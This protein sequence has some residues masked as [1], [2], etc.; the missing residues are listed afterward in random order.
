MTCA[1]LEEQ[2]TYPSGRTSQ[3][4]PTCN[5]GRISGSRS[6]ANLP[7]RSVIAAL[8]SANSANSGVPPAPD[9]NLIGDRDDAL[10][11]LRPAAA[12]QPGTIERDYRD[13]R[14]RPRSW[15]RPIHA[16]PRQSQAR[17][18]RQGCVPSARQG[19][20]LC[21]WRSAARRSSAPHPRPCCAR[22]CSCRADAHRMFLRTTNASFQARLKA[23]CMPVF[24][25]CPPAGLWTCAASPATKARPQR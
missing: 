9:W 6:P 3:V 18:G 15:C 4:P 5:G 24:M 25:P 12:M 19:S 11:R 8:G 16:G 17:R 23:S 10:A 14:S 21:R 1:S 22:G 2:A 13:S 20:S 7:T